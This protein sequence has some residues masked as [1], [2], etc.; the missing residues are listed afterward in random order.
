M[1]NEVINKFLYLKSGEKFPQTPS[2]KPKTSEAIVT[3][4][5]VF[6]YANYL[7]DGHGYLNY[8][9]R[10]EAADGSQE[11]FKRDPS[12]F[13]S[14]GSFKRDENR[15]YPE[16]FY[17]YYH[18]FKNQFTKDKTI[19]IPIV[20]LEGYDFASKMH[21]FKDDDYQ[22]VLNDAMPKWF[23]SVGLNPDNMF[24]LAYYHNNTNH[25]HIHFMMM[26]KY[27]TRFRDSFS[28]SDMNNFRNQIIKSMI[29]RARIIHNTVNEAIVPLHK[30][31]DINEINIFNE[32]NQFLIDAADEKMR[33]KLIK[34]Y[35]RI[36]EKT[37]GK[38]SLKLNSFNMRHI[39]KDIDK[40]TLEL[41]NHPLIKNQY[42]TLKEDW[43]KLDEITKGEYIK[44]PEH[45]QINEQERLLNKIGNLILKTKDNYENWLAD[46]KK[47]IGKL[48]TKKVEDKQKYIETRQFEIAS[49]RKEVLKNSAF[50]IKVFDKDVNN[51]FKNA[52]QE[53][54]K[55]QDIIK[56]VN[57]E[58]SDNHYTI[59]FENLPKNKSIKNLFILRVQDY[60]RCQINALQ[61]G[62]KTVFE[63]ENSFKNDFD[64]NSKKPEDINVDKEIKQDNEI[65]LQ[66]NIFVKISDNLKDEVKKFKDQPDNFFYVPR[67]DRKKYNRF[68]DYVNYLNQQEQDFNKPGKSNLPIINKISGFLHIAHN[69]FGESVKKAVDEY[70]F[71]KKQEEEFERMIRNDI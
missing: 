8:M 36:D 15:K 1:A 18:E 28:I 34:L 4:D 57:K 47:I 53:F 69:N 42:E 12:V 14:I 58:K 40:Y 48:E 61:D 56:L 45:Y 2:F 68:N 19:W 17:Q 60:F 9:S 10:D 64:F 62:T 50:D 65:S 30:Q 38:G 41:L 13:T 70:H 27:K 16:E 11:K 33:K 31:K 32:V 43:K 6:G 35:Y 7:D 21:L 5:S 46:Y 44:N 52:T 3:R 37:Q 20:S 39:K 66:E 59:K 67:F 71:M 63:V 49:D 29:Q 26:E 51:F 24:Y 54:F 23:R 22:S 55:N 25:P